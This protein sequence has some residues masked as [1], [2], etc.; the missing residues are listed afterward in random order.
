[1]SSK[2]EEY[3]S[4]ELVDELEEESPAVKVVE[5]N[6]FF[7]LGKKKIHKIAFRVAKK[8]EENS[9][10]IT[11]HLWLR[12]KAGELKA[13]SEDDDIM[14]D[15]K[16]V[17]I[18]LAVCRRAEEGDEEKGYMYPAFPGPQWMMDHM[19]TDQIASLLN[20]YNDFRA[21]L[22]PGFHALEFT[23][24]EAMRTLCAN[25][26]DDKTAEIVG[27]LSREWLAEAFI[28]LSGMMKRREEELDGYINRDQRDRSG[29]LPGDR[30]EGEAPADEDAQ[31][32]EQVD[33]DR[34]EDK[35]V[36]EQNVES[37]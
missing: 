35:D 30:S 37:D 7:G 25:V 13:I 15:L 11:S 14:L 1:M 27:S 32:S 9:A 36:S 2:D 10:I 24:L 31:H 3:Q 21:T 18:L 6:G 5:V 12:D 28:A 19:T 16:N 33:S 17:H 22:D 4:S 20:V 29:G 26:E 8:M 23:H 34:E